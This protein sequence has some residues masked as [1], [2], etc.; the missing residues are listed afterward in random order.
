M[1]AREGISDPLWYE[2]SKSR[3]APNRCA[4]SCRGADV[5][6]AW[7]G[8]GL[9]QRCVDTL[10]G[11]DTALAIVPAGTANLLA[12]NLGVRRDPR[13]CRGR[14]LRDTAED[15]RRHSESRVLRCDGRRR[16]RRPNDRHADGTLKDTFGRLD[17]S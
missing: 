8:D 16:I 17:S 5:I 11:T 12:S 13:G 10:A 14:A 7:G 1:L 15:R 4:R 9:A 3:Q 6:F 2:V